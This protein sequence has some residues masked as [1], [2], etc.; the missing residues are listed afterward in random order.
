MKKELCELI[1]ANRQIFDIDVRESDKDEYVKSKVGESIFYS[2]DFET[3]VN[4]ATAK[5]GHER[6]GFPYFIEWNEPLTF[7][8]MYYIVNLICSFG[9]KEQLPPPLSRIVLCYISQ[10][11][12]NRAPY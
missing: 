5:I 12:S 6:D 10:E 1:R 4:S 3:A 8:Q 11:Y 2:L 9:K 7:R